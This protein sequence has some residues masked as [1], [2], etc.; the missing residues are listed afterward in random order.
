MDI[1]AACWSSVMIKTMF[2]RVTAA[3]AGRIS[4][5]RG[6]STRRRGRNRTKRTRGL[7]LDGRCFSTYGRTLR[8]GLFSACLPVAALHGAPDL[9]GGG[10]HVPVGHPEGVQAG[11]H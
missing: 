2:G 8:S 10:R 6:M 3:V 4:G 1:E 5:N 7:R 11:P 9:L